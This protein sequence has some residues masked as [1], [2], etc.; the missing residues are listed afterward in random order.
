MRRWTWIRFA[1]S[2]AILLLIVRSV[3]VARI[4]S[5]FEAVSPWLVAAAVG[6]FLLG[7][8]LGALKWRL[9]IADEDLSPDL[10]L[11]AHFSGLAT[12]L[13][14]AGVAGGDLMRAT[15]LAP[16]V[17]RPE[18]L[19]V[20]GVVDRGVD[21]AML[22]VLATGGLLWS[23]SSGLGVHVASVGAAVLAAGATVGLM[24][25]A[26]CRRMR[27]GSL[28]RRV[29]DAAD[30][31]IRRPWRLA[32]NVGLTLTVQLLF[33]LTNVAIGRATGVEA[34]AAAWFVCWPLA[35]TAA[36]IPLGASGLGIRE[37]ALVTL[38]SQFGASTEPTFVAGLVWETVL[39]IGGLAGWAAAM[40]MRSSAP[41]P[42]P[43]VLDSRTA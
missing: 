24:F 18:S 16:A 10:W 15:W 25:L 22:V 37:A 32:A 40:S 8:V 19:A 11:K 33:V 42:A 23:H 30:A 7:H 36:L 31:A 13:C 1:V 38:M 29:A 34:S 39:F 12:S 35:K 27:P 9:L 14:V 5:A 2:A 20:A 26:A 41:E 6:V 3:P 21:A 17:R 43:I 4:R 28:P